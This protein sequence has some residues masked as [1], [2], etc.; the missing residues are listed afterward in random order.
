MG[1]TRIT[2]TIAAE[3]RQALQTMA[4]KEIRPLKDQIRYLLRQEAVKR[5]LLPQEEARYAAE[6]P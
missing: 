5:G 2:I 1:E 3:E 6:H 4:R